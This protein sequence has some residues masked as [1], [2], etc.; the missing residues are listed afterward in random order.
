[1]L[2]GNPVSNHGTP[3]RLGTG[4]PLSNNATPVRMVSGNS[5]SNHATPVRMVHRNNPAALDS[6]LDGLPQL[7]LVSRTP[8]R[9]PRSI[10]S[11]GKDSTGTA[12]LLSTLSYWDF[13]KN[14]DLQTQIA[15]LQLNEFFDQRGTP[16]NR[17]LGGSFLAKNSKHVKG[18]FGSQ[19]AASNESDWEKKVTSKKPT[20][21]SFF[22]AEAAKQKAIEFTRKQNTAMIN[23][24]DS[25]QMHR[26]EEVQQRQLETL[27][28]EIPDYEEFIPSA[29]RHRDLLL[30]DIDRAEEAKNRRAALSETQLDKH[31]RTKQQSW[32]LSRY[33]AK[34]LLVISELWTQASRGS[35]CPYG[36]D[37]PSFCRFILDVGLVDQRKVTY[38]WAV[39]KFDEKARLMRCCHHDAP[40]ATQESAPSC[41]VVS[42]ADMVLVMNAIF[43]K[44]GFGVYKAAFILNFFRVARTRLPP[45]IIEESGL[46]EDYLVTLLSGREPSSLGGPGVDD[47]NVT[48]PTSSGGIDADGQLAEDKGTD[49]QIDLE[50]L[51]KEDAWDEISGITPLWDEDSECLLASEMRREETAREILANSMLV[52]P[53]VLHLMLQYIEIFSRLHSVYAD[54]NGHMTFPLLLQFCLHFHITP[55]IASHGFLQNLYEK[56]RCLAPQPGAL[57]AAL[58]MLNKEAPDTKKIT[59]AGISVTQVDIQNQ[60]EEGGSPK[61]SKENNSSNGDGKEKMGSPIPDGRR[62]EKGQ[63]AVR[64]IGSPAAGRSRFNNQAR[65]QTQTKHLQI[66]EPHS[67]WGTSNKNSLRGAPSAASK[68]EASALRN[69][70][71]SASGQVK[72]SLEGSAD[73]S[74][75]SAATS[76]KSRRAATIADKQSPSLPPLKIPVR[77]EEQEIKTAK[78]ARSSVEMGPKGMGKDSE[79]K[80]SAGVATFFGVGAFMEVLCRAAFL[81]LGSY[82]NGQQRTASGFVRATWLL[83]YLRMVSERARKSLEK[84]PFKAAYAQLQLA[85]ERTPP[86]LWDAPPLPELEGLKLLAGD[87]P[88]LEHVMAAP[89]AAGAKS[90]QRKCPTVRL[91]Q[92]VDDDREFPNSLDACGPCIEDSECTVCGNHYVPNQWGSARCRG[93]SIVDAV[94]FQ[95][96]PWATMLQGWP[97]GIRPEVQ[98]A[99]APHQITRLDLTPPPI[100]TWEGA[101]RRA[102]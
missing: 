80:A 21:R 34:A 44:T 15:G 78:H 100:G 79:G 75:T 96:H 13:Q 6:T 69:D 42:R 81:Y 27:F 67:A 23:S 4:N 62:L 10:K 61:S 52:E 31:W 73:E 17:F 2:T 82:G 57:P 60:K 38:Y 93:C 36:M 64:P 41:Y 3:V 102:Q 55:W 53:E 1:M 26:V 20:A 9:T 66:P 99:Q 59:I 14:K 19:S 72:P 7:N 24:I 76:R 58:R 8:S 88:Q 28:F 25:S 56:A 84:R 35:S 22:A 30:S 39:S 49:I 12:S 29:V 18:S 97:S 54:G 32:M 16:R 86:E 33:E 94:G 85:L 37:R 89:L 65:A 50:T 74:P 95:H 46:R 47:Q 83:A 45:Y 91:F 92:V 98:A 68:D 101:K 63:A 77:L 90:R 51:L 48:T 40:P 43:H 5:A 87:V 11:D 70:A 71:K